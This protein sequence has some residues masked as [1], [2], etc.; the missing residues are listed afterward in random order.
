MFVDLHAYEKL[1]AFL[2]S[3]LFDG[4]S[5]E[6]QSQQP[7]HIRPI[8]LAASVEHAEKQL[9]TRCAREC[10]P[11]GIPALA[12]RKDEIPRLLDG[13]FIELK[14]A[15]RICELGEA[16]VAALRAFA[17]PQE[18]EDLRR[19]APRLLAIIEHR[20]LSGAARALAVA[21]Q[22]LSAALDRLGVDVNDD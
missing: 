19:A 7:Y 3:H 8:V 4:A 6:P 9:G 21:R 15:R 17:W 5:S 16:N 20:T 11:V 18:M 1:P 2:V 22:T 10:R 12:E 14:S 13:L